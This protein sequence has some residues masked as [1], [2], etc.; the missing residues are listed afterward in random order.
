[1]RGNNGSR[2]Y[3]QGLVGE[4]IPLAGRITAVADVFDALS[5]PRP[6]KPAYTREHCL[7]VMRQ[8][9]GTQFDPRVLAAFMAAQ[10]AIINIQRHLVDASNPWHVAVRPRWPVKSARTRQRGAVAVNEVKR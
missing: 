4:A 10:P 7:F 1:M 3:P 5:S 8:H 2:E 9:I 6:Y